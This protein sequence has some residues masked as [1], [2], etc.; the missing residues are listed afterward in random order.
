[1]IRVGLWL[2]VAL[3]GA[4]AV[5]ATGAPG[6]EPATPV[7]VA[8]TPRSVFDS[9]EMP[10]AVPISLRIE[11]R[12]T[13]DDRLRGGSTPLATDV[14]PHRTRLVAGQRVMEAVPEGIVIPSGS[15]LTLEP[16]NSHLMLID[17]QQALVQGQT[18]PLTLDFERAGQIAVTVRVRRKVDAAGVPPIPP[19]AVGDLAISLVSA[20][21]APAATPAMP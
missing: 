12:G 14:A 20:P 9:G 5:G 4:L 17:L 7:A 15:T 13:R 16:G 6:A 8:G 3:A 2:A 10:G 1:M 21:P 18:F 19:V 11:N